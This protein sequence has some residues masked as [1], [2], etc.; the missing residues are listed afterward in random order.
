MIFVFKVW[1]KFCKELAQKGI[2]SIT[3]KQ[4]TEDTK[5]YLVL[6]HDV[7]T[8]VKKAFE[9]AKIEHK[10]NHRSSFYVQAY[11]LESTKNISLLKEMQNMGHEISYHYDVMDSNKGNLEKAN[12]EFS[13]NKKIFE[14]NGFSLVTVCQ[15]GNPVVERIGY[16]SNRDFFRSDKI[17]NLHPN[18]L[19]IMVNFKDKIPTDYTYFSDAGRKFKMI[20][21]PINNDII[22][23][24]S[25]D[26]PFEN[27]DKLFKVIDNSGR[28]IISTHPHR[29][30][31]ST[32]IY[33][34]KAIIFK[35][36]RFVAK[37][38]LK[39]QFFK[40]IM[41]RFYFLAKKI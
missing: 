39:I 28:Y 27:L 34:F 30:T 25:M 2:I 19:D 17:Q 31:S 8:D 6:K 10:Y 15:H 16:T 22:D 20:F 5:N 37:I 11:L 13:K 14:E 21:D 7:E 35:T 1:D 23:S 40:R 9:M 29:W 12:L 41:S 4:V 36:V 32:F 38:L 26:I 3:A 18:I 24:S 33:L